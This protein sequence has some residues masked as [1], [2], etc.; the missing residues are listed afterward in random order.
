MQYIE[1]KKGHFFLFVVVI[2]LIIALVLNPEIYMES[3]LKGI[4]VWATAVLPALFPFF[5]LTKLLTQLKLVEKIAQVFQPI[6][7]K[8]FN[9]PGVASYVFLMSIISGYPVGAKITSELYENGTI[10]RGQATRMCSFCSTSGPLFIIGTVGVEMF[11]CKGAGIIMLASHIL[12]AILNGLLYRNYNKK[13]SLIKIQSQ[14]KP[15]PIDNILANTIYDSVISILIVGGYIA[16]FFMFIDVLSHFYV[17][18][19][20]SSGLGWLLNLVG[21]NSSTSIGLASGIIEVTRGCLDLSQS[22]ASIPLLCVLGTGLISWGG[23][24]VHFQSITFLQKCN[25]KIGFYILQKM[26]HAIFAMLICLLFVLFI[27]L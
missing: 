27:P 22:G 13:E 4:M 8:L 7:S 26:T 24:S 1:I 16:L 15:A 18:D 11:L 10:T 21:I 2:F 9:V 17:L 20:V 5:F 6:T 23:L 19:W 25:I 3:T 12:G 14:E